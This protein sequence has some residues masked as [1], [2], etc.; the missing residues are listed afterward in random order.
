[1]GEDQDNI[2]AYAS[3][4][5]R[6]T[7]QIRIPT[8]K[9]VYRTNQNI[10]KNILKLIRRIESEGEI[11]KYSDLNPIYSRSPNITKKK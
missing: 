11:E 1:M 4:W 10:Y 8:N 3:S 6:N 2:Q 5:G 7:D 9:H